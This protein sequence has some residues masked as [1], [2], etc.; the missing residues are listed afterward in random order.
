MFSTPI[1]LEKYIAVGKSS[2]A[3]SA[4]FEYIFQRTTALSAPSNPAT[5]QMSCLVP[6]DWTDGPVE[7]SGLYRFEWTAT[8]SQTDTVWSAFSSPVLWAKLDAAGADSADVEYVFQLSN[9][10]SAPGTPP[11]AQMNGFVPQHWTNDPIGV[12]SLKQYEWSVFRSKTDT[13]WSA[14][15]PPVLWAKFSANGTGS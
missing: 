6:K 5:A 10:L 3:D 14:Y 15:S 2:G 7:C 4:D 8:R 1:V 11:T 12:D 9:G 13:G